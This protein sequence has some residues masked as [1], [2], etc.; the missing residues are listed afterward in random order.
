[1]SREFEINRHAL[2][3]FLG[4]A[5]QVQLVFSEVLFFGRREERRGE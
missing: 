1:M 4:I 3:Q 5:D 2:I